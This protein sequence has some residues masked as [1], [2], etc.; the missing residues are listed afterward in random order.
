MSS[1]ES[2]CLLIIDA[3]KDFHEGGSL[4]IPG[5]TE[6]SIKISNFIK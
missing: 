4:A 5:A 3:Q 6:D 2:V 1:S